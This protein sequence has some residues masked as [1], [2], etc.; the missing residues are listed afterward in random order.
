M[1]LNDLRGAL[2]HELRDLYSAEKQLVQALPRMAKEASNEE[3]SAAIDEHLDVTKEHVER[4]E[5]MFKTLDVS[6]RGEKCRGMEGLIEEGRHILEQE[7]AD[8]VRDALIIS[9]A[10]KI[11]HYEIAGYGTARTF[12]NRLGEADVANLLDRTLDEESDA[13]E[14][15]TEIAE[16]SVNREAEA[17]AR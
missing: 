2:I 6:S 12:A 17:I 9:A 4:L 3:L 16:S 13:D 1:K 5:E 7:A 14:T 15:L 11:E 10:Q 8:E